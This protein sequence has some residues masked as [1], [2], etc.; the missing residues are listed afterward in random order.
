MG[1]HIIA[2]QTIP[3][4]GKN[5]QNKD[6]DVM[7]KDGV[8]KW[9]SWADTR[10]IWAYIGDI[11]KI[12]AFGLDGDL[13]PETLKVG[14]RGTLLAACKVSEGHMAAIERLSTALQDNLDLV[15]NPVEV[16]TAHLKVSALTVNDLSPVDEMRSLIS[17][18]DALLGVV[19]PSERQAV[20]HDMG[21]LS[22]HFEEEE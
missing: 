11:A 12:M 21:R 17:K 22:A 15:A 10:R 3:A 7:D 16:Q 1:N 9:S 4:K 5:R 20:L 13:Y 8:P 19:D 2:T 14:G 6:F 18:L